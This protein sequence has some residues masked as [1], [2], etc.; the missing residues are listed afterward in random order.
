M[1][2]FMA[3]AAFPMSSKSAIFPYFAIGAV[4]EKNASPAPIVSSGMPECVGQW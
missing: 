3:P 1:A 4:T 2:H